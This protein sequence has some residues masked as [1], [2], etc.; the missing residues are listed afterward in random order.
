MI[1]YT[2]VPGLGTINIS[3]TPIVCDL[4]GDVQL[5]QVINSPRPN[6]QVLNMQFHENLLANG[7]KVF[8]RR[9]QTL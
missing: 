9:I 1:H 4:D 3:P 2:Q 5:T 6:L 7:I 8:D